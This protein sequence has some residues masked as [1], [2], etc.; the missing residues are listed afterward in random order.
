MVNDN[1]EYISAVNL[2]GGSKKYIKD[3]EVREIVQGID[4]TANNYIE[5]KSGQREYLSTIVP[6]G[7]I[8]MGS[9]AMG[10]DE[11]VYTYK[12][13]TKVSE[14]VPTVN[15]TDIRSFTNSTT[16]TRDYFQARLFSGQV[17]TN[18]KIDSIGRKNLS[19]TL[20][21]GEH[22]LRLRHSGANTDINILSYSVVLTEETTFN[23]SF[24]VVGYDASTVGGLSL[25]N[26]MLNEGST[27]L[28]YEPYGAKK[29]SFYSN[30]SNLTDYTIYGAAGGVGDKT[31]QLFDVSTATHE[32]ILWATGAVQS[33]DR[34]IMSGY[35]PVETGKTYTCSSAVWFIGYD[36]NDT[37]LGTYNEGVWDKNGLKP[38][39]TFVNSATLNAA[40][41]RLLKNATT[42]SSVMLNEGST[43]LPYEPYGKYKIPVIC[44]GTTNN[45]YLANPL[46]A[47]DSIDYTTSQVAIPT[48]DGA[49][50]L[51]CDTTVQPSKVSL[52][53]TGWHS[54][55][56]II[57]SDIDS[58][59]AVKANKPYVLN[60]TLTF[61]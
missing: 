60:N 18:Q 27:A 59:N 43:A 47:T 5:L 52:T 12:S 42:M 20:P 31:A 45:I 8:P 46:G 15:L 19:I 14:G 29:T 4:S 25:D 10:F 16:D 55:K 26:I 39:T 17:I 38:D 21:A 34:F 30:G 24:D 32:R 6:T 51:I 41:I 2:P 50:N 13:G 7:N 11:G 56:E 28:P 48:V 22:T 49:N 3:E 37:Y 9:V 54:D 53:Y 61:N 40:K 35:I 36:S 33:D 57:E 44:G 58:L 1:R 23:C